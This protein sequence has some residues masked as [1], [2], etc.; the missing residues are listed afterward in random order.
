MFRAART[1]LAA[2]L[3][4]RKW[5][6]PVLLLLIA[7]LAI[8][9][10]P[11][12]AKQPPG[13]IAQPVSAAFPGEG[14]AYRDAVLETLEE[15]KRGAFDL[16]LLGGLLIVGT[17]FLVLEF[18]VL[19]RVCRMVLGP[20][21]ATRPPRKT[22]A[23]K[24]TA[25]K[26]EPCRQALNVVK[27]SAQT[28]PNTEDARQAP[29]AYSAGSLGLPC[30]PAHSVRACWHGGF[31]HSPTVPDLDSTETLRRSPSSRA[32]CFS[33]SAGPSATQDR[34]HAIQRGRPLCLP[35]TRDRVGTVFNRFSKLN[36]PAGTGLPGGTES[37]LRKRHR[38]WTAGRGRSRRTYP[39]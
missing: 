17:T 38:K 12:A 29:P 30:S 14:G 28:E 33:A 32:S 11:L 9:P 15:L 19:K 18:D 10:A 21:S 1:L 25:C 20:H 4:E 37:V 3:G 24:R 22:R 39:F 8:L 31:G 34:P 13:P 26:N 35:P 36:N 6:A 16:F 2:V 27:Q 23:A 7:G 5:V